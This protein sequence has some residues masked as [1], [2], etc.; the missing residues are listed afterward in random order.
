MTLP[1]E[2]IPVV[3]LILGWLLSAAG[4]WSKTRREERVREKLRHESKTDERVEF[5]RQTLLELQD[6]LYQLVRAA[7]HAYHEDEMAHKTTGVWGRNLITEEWDQKEYEAR[8]R[9]NILVV[10]VANNALRE[11]LVAFQNLT[12]QLNLARSVDVA[13]GLFL[14]AADM[15][16]EINNDMG[17]LIRSA[18]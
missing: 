8:V 17:A 16:E 18:Y 5:Q 2:L 7:G 13:A 15:F 14:E 1:Y 3:T 9:A 12:T 4:S 10:R 6:V 11:K